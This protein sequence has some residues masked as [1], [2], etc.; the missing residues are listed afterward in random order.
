MQF[1]LATLE[2]GLGQINPTDEQIKNYIETLP[3]ERTL[4][5]LNKLPNNIRK[6]FC[7]VSNTN[8]ASSTTYKEAMPTIGVAGAVGSGVGYYLGGIGGA[9]VGALIGGIGGYYAKQEG[10]V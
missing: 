3:K 5:I 7:G 6:E 9:V 2:D 4:N 8:T 10:I 1:T